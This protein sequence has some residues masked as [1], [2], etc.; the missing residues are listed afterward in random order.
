VG[1]RC[2]GAIGGDPLLRLLQGGHAGRVAADLAFRSSVR[3][4]RG[5]S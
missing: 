2:F 3:F 5:I 1:H 4:A